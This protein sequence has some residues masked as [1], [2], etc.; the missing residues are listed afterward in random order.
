[1]PKTGE[2]EQHGLVVRQCV[3]HRTSHCGG[4]DTLG[5]C[6]QSGPVD[7]WP[8]GRALAKGGV[9]RKWGPEGPVPGSHF[10]FSLQGLTTSI[11]GVLRGKFFSRLGLCR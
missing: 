5:S 4:G 6:S 2:G 3:L 7:E 1:M 11:T 10:S 9:R 8:P